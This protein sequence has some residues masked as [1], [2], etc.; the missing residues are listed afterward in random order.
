MT[1]DLY[2]Y[3]KEIDWSALHL[4]VNI[5]ISL[6]N[7]FYENIKI[8]LQKGETKKIKLLVEGTEYPAILTNIYFDETKYPTHKELLQIRW[9]PNSAIAQQLRE[10]FNS[11][12]S[13]LFVEKEKLTNKRKQL[14]VPEEM[15]EYLAIYSTV[16]DDVFAIECITHNEIVE[17][18]QEI[19]NFNELELEQIIQ[20]TDMPAFIEKTKTTKIRKLDKTIG[21]NLKRLYNYKCQ[22]C[23]LFIGETY[24]ATVIHTHHIEYFSISLNNNADNIMVICPNHHG[25][26]HATNPVFNRETKLFTY[27]NGLSEGLKLNL[28]L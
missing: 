8:K 4:G 25:I 22:I 3:K 13:Y 18:K 2:I 15:R 14:S 27:P 5:P 20:A 24:N 17:T 28:H 26:V 6:Q 16:F 21:D 9:S 1:T 23:G 7:I 11:S 10:I 12:Y 19:R